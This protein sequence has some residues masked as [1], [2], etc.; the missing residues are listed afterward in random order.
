MTT[1]V[2]KYT[3]R[4]ASDKTDDWPFWF[5]QN[6]YG[7][8]VTAELVRKHID[9]NQQGATLTTRAFAQHIAQ[10]ANAV[11]LNPPQEPKP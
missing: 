4:S 6:Q 7:L 5:V 8:N 3:A 9:P 2:A 10:I 11:R 1:T